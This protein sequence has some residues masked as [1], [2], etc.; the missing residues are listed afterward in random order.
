MKMCF[1]SEKTLEDFVCEK[2][3]DE[4]YFPITKKYHQAWFRQVKIPEYGIPDIILLDGKTG[5]YD[6]QFTIVEL[7]NTELCADHL[8]QLGRYMTAFRRYIGIGQADG[9]RFSG[10]VLVKGILAG[11]FDPKKS[12]LLWL[13]RHTRDILIFSVE[14]DVEDGFQ[15]QLVNKYD[16]FLRGEDFAPLS[17]IRQACNDLISKQ[18]RTDRK[19]KKSRGLE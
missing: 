16:W 19:A 3:E 10:D 7:K 2:L 8:N 12:N 9:K 13:Y 11:P 18:N 14:V 5:M 6:A 15:S 17:D 4:N 1:P